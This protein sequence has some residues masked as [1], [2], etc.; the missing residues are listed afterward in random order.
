[1]LIALPAATMAA[2]PEGEYY[3]YWAEPDSVASVAAGIDSYKVSGRYV[4]VLTHEE[5]PQTG[6][7]AMIGE[8]FDCADSSYALAEMVEYDGKNIEIRH[9]S[10]ADIKK[11]FKP[12]E[13]D[14]R[15]EV[16]LIGVCMEETGLPY[17]QAAMRKHFMMIDESMRAL[18]K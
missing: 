15:Q 7:Y 10:N 17:D 5:N 14:S 2:L 11:M 4:A 9:S 3:L 1:M 16:L 18:D 6:Q 8:L 13:E 12:V